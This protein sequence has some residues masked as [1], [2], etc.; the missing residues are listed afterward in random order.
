MT[1]HG[2]QPPPPTNTPLI[3]VLTPVHDP[4]L[5]MLED[6][7]ASVRAQTF[8]N[9]ELCLVDDGS[10][11]PEIIAALERHAATDP[12]IHLT[13]RDTAGGISAATNAA[14]ETR[15]RPTT[16]PCSTTTTPSPPTPSN[17][18]PTG[19]PPNPTST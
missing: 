14:L 13:R 16:S 12:R 8:T 17:T 18:S 1:P 7:I 5:H 19:S 9:W 2:P 15:H 6:T 11:N 3:S 10:T 4:P